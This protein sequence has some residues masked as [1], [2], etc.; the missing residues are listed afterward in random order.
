MK[1]TEKNK[2]ILSGVSDSDP[3]ANFNTS[4]GSNSL[5]LSF[6]SSQQ[7]PGIYDKHQDI[8]KVNH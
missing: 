4:L 6:N 3:N 7:Q 5:T 1:D 2:K 8:T